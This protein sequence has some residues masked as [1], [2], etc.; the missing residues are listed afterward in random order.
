MSESL[1]INRV[2]IVGRLAARPTVKRL[3]SGKAL[4]TLRIETRDRYKDRAGEMQERVEQ[5]PCILW[6]ERSVA[7]LPVGTML[8]IEGR[9]SSRSYAARGETRWAT[10]LV[11]EKVVPLGDVGA[12]DA[13]PGSANLREATSPRSAPPP[14]VPGAPLE[15]GDIPF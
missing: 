4:T 6:G 11:G 12:S 3:P 10:E 5:H 8:Y 15:D 2:A 13:G 7:A 9:L 14:A 1:S